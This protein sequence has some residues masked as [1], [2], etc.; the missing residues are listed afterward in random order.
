MLRPTLRQFFAAASIAVVVVVVAAFALFRRSSRESI[1]KA[2][3]QQQEQAATR[4][5]AR[6]VRELGRARRAL[7]DVERGIHTGA[8]SVDD[9]ASL[10][11]TL[12]TRLSAEPHLVELTFT[13]ATLLG[14]DENGEAKLAPGG[15]SQLSLARARSGRLVTKSMR[16]TGETG[17]FEVTTRERASDARFDAATFR[18]GGAA[19][20]PTSHPTFTVIAR[21]DLRNETIWSDLHWSELDQNA[22]PEEQR[23]V[24]SVQKTIVDSAGT[25]LGV[26]RAGLV[27][28]ELDEIARVQTTPGDTEDVQGPA[29]EPDRPEPRSPAPERR[30]H[31]PR[32]R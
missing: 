29:R 16:R 27:T 28:S 12:F 11:A 32:R 13:R 15:R 26:L 31:A 4:I 10:E 8:T 25:F 19:A 30:G 22:A 9:P 21:H 14:Y 6:V 2:A 17:P 23:V 3:Q 24:V 7:E 1:L 18:P 5:E 20:D